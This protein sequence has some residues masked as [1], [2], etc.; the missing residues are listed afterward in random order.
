MKK[1][2]I[3]SALLL[4]LTANAEFIGEGATETTTVKN[5]IELTDDSRVIVEGYIVK[6]LKDELYLFK[7]KSG[8]V[9][10]EIDDEDFRNIKITSKDKIRITAEVDSDWSNTSLEAKYLELAK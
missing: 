5:A 3:G 10:M 6:Q 8:E 4:S 7:D 1:L 9:E 2:L